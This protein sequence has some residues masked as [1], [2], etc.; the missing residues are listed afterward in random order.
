MLLDRGSGIGNWGSGIGDWLP[1]LV[2]SLAGLAEL[3]LP[4]KATDGVGQQG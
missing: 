1:V 4:S 3:C 2:G